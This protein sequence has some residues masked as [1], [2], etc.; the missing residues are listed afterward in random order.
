MQTLEEAKPGEEQDTSK[1]YTN[2]QSVAVAGDHPSLQ[3]DMRQSAGVCHDAALARSAGQSAP[4]VLRPT[5][6]KSPGRVTHTAP[7][8]TT[9]SSSKVLKQLSVEEQK[10]RHS[11]L[12]SDSTLASS[13]FSFPACSTD[14]HS[15]EDHDVHAQSSQQS[16]ARSKPPAALK[17]R[18]ALLTGFTTCS[19]ERSERLSI[20]KERQQATQR[21][22]H[23]HSETSDSPTVTRSV[24]GDSG[25]D[26]SA[27]LT[28]SMPER[29]ATVIGGRR[30]E[31]PISDG[32]VNSEYLGKSSES[33]GAGKMNDGQLG[34]SENLSNRGHR[35]R[36]SSRPAVVMTPEKLEK[37]RAKAAMW[38]ERALHNKA[39][40]SFLDEKESITS[41]M[42]ATR[43]AGVRANKHWELAELYVRYVPLL[44]ISAAVQAAKVMQECLHRYEESSRS[45]E[46]WARYA[47]THLLIRFKANET[48]GPSGNPISNGPAVN[49]EQHLQLAVQAFEHAARLSGETTEFA[50]HCY[51]FAARAL[52]GWP[53]QIYF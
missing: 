23:L 11:S 7:P 1:Q 44:G 3:M 35:R 22:L 21:A 31:P 15:S 19:D 14:H 28:E 53:M 12:S 41:R 50:G 8:S 49:P 26:S 30:N 25:T 51:A 27:T 34:A 16:S 33:A 18:R 2:R 52:Q 43:D 5:S 37:A 40:Q 24:D 32:R 4:Q 10:S 29:A 46:R 45:P 13:T 36:K 48:A 47:Q 20:T 38:A 9:L 39:R 6:P 17:T 42:F